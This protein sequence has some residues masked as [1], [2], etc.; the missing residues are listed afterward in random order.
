MPRFLPG[1]VTLVVQA[2]FP[3]TPGK[4]IIQGARL[5]PISRIS[6]DLIEAGGHLDRSGLRS[7]SVVLVNQ[8]TQEVPTYGRVVDG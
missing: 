6:D 8:S 7:S 4:P 5:I 3:R 1:I 2:L